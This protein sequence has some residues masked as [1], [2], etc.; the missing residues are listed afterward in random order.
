M[1]QQSSNTFRI[2]VDGKPLGDDLMQ[3]MVSAFVDDSLNLPD[4]F[5]LAFRD[6]GRDVLERAGIEIGKKITISVVSDASPGGETLISKAEVTALEAE[7]EPA[8]TLSV[9][10]GLDQSHRL[11]R[12]R[13]T[14]S[15]QNATYADI[16]KKVA[17]R[18]GIA[19]GT[20][21]PT[22]EVRADVSQGNVSDWDFL[23][24]LAAKVGY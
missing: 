12:G 19:L 22:T 3:S 11:F 7:F 17:Q 8:G 24:A 21:D 1:V 5:V 20:I 2:E 4:M 9:V 13:R 16:A 14:E 23:R 15:Y 6:P 10:R 18:A